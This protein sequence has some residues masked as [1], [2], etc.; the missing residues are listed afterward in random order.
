MLAAACLGAALAAVQA[1]SFA[2]AFAWAGKVRGRLTNGPVSP[3]WNEDGS[4]FWYESRPAPGEKR[5]W[6]VDCQPAKKRPAFDHAIA[7]EAIK[8]LTGKPADPARL[9]IDRLRFSSKGLALWMDGQPYLLDEA[10]RS[11]ARLPEEASDSILYDPA[12][13]PGRSQSG[14]EAITGRIIN[15]TGSAAALFWINTEGEAVAY[16]EIAAGAS[17]SRPTF[18][19]HLWE[20]RISGSA[21]ARFAFT[22]TQTLAVLEDRTYPAFRSRPQRQEE[23]MQVRFAGS[24]AELWVKGEKVFATTDGSEADQYRGPAAWS[25]DRKWAVFFK[26]VPSPGRKVTIVRSSPAGQLQPETIV[27]DYL[28]PGDVIDRP[29]VAVLN[30]EARTVSL[31]SDSLTPTPWIID[32][33]EWSQDSSEFTFKYNQRGHQVMRVVA[34]R[35]GTLETRTAILEEAKTFI[36]WTGKVFFDRIDKAEAV[37][38]SE[39]SGWNHLYLWD[40]AK[41]AVK[42]PITQ[43]EWVV[44]GDVQVDEARRE[45]L[46][47]GAGRNL[48]E[49]PYN[50]HLYRVRL[51]GTGLT[52]LTPGDGD[53]RVLWGPGRRFFVDVWSRPD[54][55]PISVLRNADGKELLRLEEGSTAALEA[56]GW[57]GPQRF[58]APGRDGTTP[59]YGLIHRPSKMEPGRKY[60]V[61]EAIYA[62]PHAAHVPKTFREVSDQQALAELGYI[63]VQ[64]DGM[65]T[66]HRSKAFHDVC[67]QNIADAGFPDRIAWIKAAAEEFPELDI[68]RVGIYGTS[69]GGQN[70]LH[71]VQLHSNF[72][73][74]AVA[75]CGCYDNR[76]DKIWWNEQWMGWPIGLH[77]EA[78]SGST[79]APKLGGR[80]LLLLG[81]VDTNVDPASTMQVVNALIRAGKDF[82][83][84]VMPNVGHGALGSPYAVRRMYRFFARHLQGKAD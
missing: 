38:M 57:Q 39:R 81:E 83:L 23:E 48:G 22:E 9:P 14:G 63:V 13:G 46:F 27:M 12:T 37:W 76:M 67:W 58:I 1:D 44:R 33:V 51:D 4:A 75:D 24:Q 25:P 55:A 15:K 47:M 30:V 17:I 65:G 77:Y 50:R 56:A 59:I 73:K 66:S 8:A 52:D 34:V 6:L 32:Q 42:N 64:I 2:P 21:K 72:Y 5:F 7:A 54:L 53:H 20:L 74:A 79:L 84:L 3:Q 16:G 78:Q 29:R 61:I 80:L 43:G 10:K 18:E 31:V 62:G 35:P 60:P 69:A 28:K 11:L 40:L 71:A 82:E 19:G 36:D 26:T 49:D 68:T 70:A 45:V 41:G